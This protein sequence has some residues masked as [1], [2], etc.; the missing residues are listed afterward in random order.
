[1]NGRVM[2]L[3]YIPVLET[4]FWEF[5]SPLAYGGVAPMVERLAEDQRGV[6]STPTPST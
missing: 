6:G 5:D 3:V 4:G 2:E 1:M